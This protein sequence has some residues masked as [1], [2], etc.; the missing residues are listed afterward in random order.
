[1]VTPPP[2]SYS[3]VSS[4]ASPLSECFN[5]EPSTCRAFLAQCAL[6]FEL[7]PSSFPL[8]RSKIAYLIM[9]MSGRALTWATTIWVQQ[10]AIC[11]SLE[12]LVGEV[13]KVFDGQFSGREAARKLIQLWQDASN[14]ADHAVDFRMLAEEI[15]WTQ[16]ALFYM[17]LHG[18]S[19]EDKEELASREFP[20]DLDSLIAL[21]IHINGQLQE[22]RM[23]WKF[24][25]THTSRDSTSPPSHP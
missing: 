6:I 8:D 22:R 18:I 13:R 9:L 24:D 1:M 16:E 7:Q 23:E 15:V 21:T 11:A 19:E 25:F 4:A 14:M 10:P 5:G 3:A 2:L 17:F 20:T 12:G